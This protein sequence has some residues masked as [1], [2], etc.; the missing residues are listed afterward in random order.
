MIPAPPSVIK[1]LNV[2]PNATHVVYS[3]NWA[4]ASW[5]SYPAG[6]FTSV[7]G[8]FTVPTPKLA[9]G[10]TNKYASASAWVGID[11]DTCQTAIIQTGIDFT[12]SN[13][14]VTY[15][16]WYEWWPAFAEDFDNFAVHA[17]DVIIVTATATSKT[18][19]K[20]SI[21]NKTTGHTVSKSL[22]SSSAL[23]LE[24][25]EWIVEDYEEGGSEVP[26]A[27]FGTVNFQHAVATTKWK[28]TVGAK[29]A[30]IIDLVLNSKV[31]TSV[32]TTSSEV[33]VKYLK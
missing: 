33:T 10:A 22:T 13:G 5:E 3:G 30:Q 12:I 27:N 23:C 28:A 20:V 6:T 7:T 1:A 18:S 8:Q 14:K 29:G 25:A 4:G 21:E 16:A 15:D 32:S 31:V 17:G 11:G 2:N 9:A 19:G 24:N 26:F